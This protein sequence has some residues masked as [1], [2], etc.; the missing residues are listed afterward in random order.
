MKEYTNVN[1][2]SSAAGY[3]WHS[4]P[5]LAQLYNLD[6]NLCLQTYKR[7]VQY[8]VISVNASGTDDDYALTL[9]LF[10]TSIESMQ[11]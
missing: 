8:R 6:V 11:P 5:S 3:S 1:R 2:F 9:A 10:N 4:Y 7:T